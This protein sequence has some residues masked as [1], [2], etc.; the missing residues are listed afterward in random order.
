MSHVWISHTYTHPLRTYTNGGQQVHIIESR[1]HIITIIHTTYA[2]VMSHMNKSC[3]SYESVTYIHIRYMRTPIEVH[4]NESCWHTNTIIHNQVIRAEAEGWGAH[5]WVILHTN[6]S[7][8]TYE[9]V[10][11]INMTQSYTSRSY[12]RKRR[13]IG[14]H[15][16]VETH[17]D[18]SC[19]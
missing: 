1:R 14:A 8:P 4:I 3:H 6:K 11:H 19:P 16:W 15:E 17:T 7:C 2:W 5:E 9:H 13:A 10:T 12:A 18:E